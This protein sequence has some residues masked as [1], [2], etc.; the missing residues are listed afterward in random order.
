MSLEGKNISSV[1]D[2]CK[3]VAPLSAELFKICDTPN[4]QYN[5]LNACGMLSGEKE[6]LEKLK[7]REY[8]ESIDRIDMY[9]AAYTTQ[10]FF[11][12]TDENDNVVGIVGYEVIDLPEFKDYVMISWTVVSESMRSKGI[13]SK[14]LER[15]EQFLR[16]EYPE[17]KYFLVESDRW[18][19]V[20]GLD[21]IIDE[22]KRTSKFYLKN[23]YKSLGLV[24]NVKKKNILPS[25]FFEDNLDEVLIKEM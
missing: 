6:E 24:K 21:W 8:A 18:T 10:Q 19:Y 2:Y 14:M 1:S 20:A 9:Y 16:Q 17:K 5:L 7:N 11:G 12:F 22:N 25:E 15:L 3:Y 4:L 13:G 23:G